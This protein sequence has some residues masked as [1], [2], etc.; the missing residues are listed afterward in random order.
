VIG[1]AYSSDIT[2]KTCTQ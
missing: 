2:N 1:S